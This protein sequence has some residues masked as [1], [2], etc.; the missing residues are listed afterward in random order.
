MHC[1]NTFLLGA[2]FCAAPSDVLVGYTS[3]DREIYLWT[4]CHEDCHPDGNEMCPAGW[5]SHTDS[6]KEIPSDIQYHR[7]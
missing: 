1:F 6:A 7:G 3:Y 5:K 4:R 2:L